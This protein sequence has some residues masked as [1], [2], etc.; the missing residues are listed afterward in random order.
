MGRKLTPSSRESKRWEIFATLALVLFLA[1]SPALSQTATSLVGSWT[2]VWGGNMETPV[3][4]TVD[5]HKGTVVKGTAT[6]TDKETAHT[7]T[8]TATA[9]AQ[10]GKLVLKIEKL[11]RSIEI[12]GVPEGRRLIEKEFPIAFELTLTD[13]NALKGTGKSHRHDGPVQ[14]TKN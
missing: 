14:L 1:I 11:V 8:F 4:L 7:Y 6:L 12:L 3:R 13:D 2:G 10:D 9:A 5:S